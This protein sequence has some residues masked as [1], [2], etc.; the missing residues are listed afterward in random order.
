VNENS[1]KLNKAK[2]LGVPIMNLEDFLK[3]IKKI[4]K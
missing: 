4:T 1:L 2:E 3:E